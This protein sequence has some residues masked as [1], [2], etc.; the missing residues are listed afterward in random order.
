MLIVSFPGER[1]TYQRRIVQPIVD[2]SAAD[3]VGFT[4]RRDGRGG[5]DNEASMAHADARL[6]HVGDSAGKSSARFRT[7]GVGGR[8]A[9]LRERRHDHCANEQKRH[10]TIRVTGDIPFK[11]V[12]RPFNM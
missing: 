10:Q 6:R 11:H 7:E 8:R 3:E 9:A 1:L 12:V 4:A 5:T 2:L